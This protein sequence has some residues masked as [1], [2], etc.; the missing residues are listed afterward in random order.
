VFVLSPERW[1]NRLAGNS[2][3]Q[4]EEVQSLSP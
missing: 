1:Q 3:D 2:Q 4:R